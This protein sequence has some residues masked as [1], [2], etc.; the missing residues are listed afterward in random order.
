MKSLL[1][2]LFFSYL[3]IGLNAQGDIKVFEKVEINAH[4]DPNL[5]NSHIRKYTKIPDSL[6]KSVPPG[7]YKA[8][9]LFIVD[10]HGIIG[11]IKLKDDPGFGLGQMA[12]EA[13]KS[14]RGEWKPAVQCGRNVKSYKEQ[15][16]SF[17][18]PVIQL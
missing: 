9:V 8:T 3:A 15:T 7:T 5:W 10:V 11:Q 17:I 18:I 14:Y 16:V 12:I 1:T 4:T 2:C 6:M 13:I